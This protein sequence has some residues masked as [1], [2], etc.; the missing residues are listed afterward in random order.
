MVRVSVKTVCEYAVIS[1][2]RVCF[3]FTCLLIALSGLH[4]FLMV[5]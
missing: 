4:R 5:F 3:K 2:F 1:Q